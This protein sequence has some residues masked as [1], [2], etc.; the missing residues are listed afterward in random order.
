MSTG[1]I[2][3]DSIVIAIFEKFENK[4]AIFKEFITLLVQH[5]RVNGVVESVG[6]C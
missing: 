1:T 3:I 2:D 5:D 6:K 4:H